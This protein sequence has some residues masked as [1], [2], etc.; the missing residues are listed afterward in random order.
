MDVVIVDYGSGNLQSVRQAL[1]AASAN[2]TQ[3]IN[4]VLSA[5]PEQVA[6]ADALVLPGVGS[7]GDCAGALTA[8]W[9][10]REAIVSSV[11]KRGCPFLG[12]CVGMQLM[13]E[14]GSEGGDN[15][16][17]GWVSGSVNALLPQDKTL[18]IPHMGWNSLNFTTQHPVWNGIADGSAVY[19]LHGYSF[20]TTENVLAQ[21][22]YGGPVIASIG[23]DNMVGVQFHPE[24]SQR[25]GQQIL[26]NWL[27]W[28]P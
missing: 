24:K 1:L 11:L 6:D 21:A 23:I 16:G 12:I 9:G 20:N 10:M 15:E 13:A 22:D 4:V 17:F 5:E 28:K 8:I 19:F 18:K 7:F 3:N 25:I 26:I 14:T 27:N 2:T